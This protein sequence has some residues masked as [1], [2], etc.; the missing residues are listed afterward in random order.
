MLQKTI[1]RGRGLFVAP[2]SN[3]FFIAGKNVDVFS[4]TE[5][6]IIQENRTGAV[7]AKAFHSGC[8][9]FLKVRFLI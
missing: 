8:L 1:I 7:H 4:R 3:P 2:E 9:S 5:T 6:A